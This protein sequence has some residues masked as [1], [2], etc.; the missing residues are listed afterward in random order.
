MKPRYDIDELKESWKELLDAEDLP[1]ITDRYKKNVT[2]V[3]LENTKE[4]LLE[5]SEQQ[6]N[7]AAPANQSNWGS[8]A[9]MQGYDPVLI[10]MIRQAIPKLMAFD[11]AGVQPLQGPVGLIFALT[12][13]YS[14]QDGDPMLFNEPDTTFSGKG[15]QTGTQPLP[16][17][18]DA[19]YTTG[20]GLTTLEGETPGDGVG[21]DFA[22]VSF[23]ITKTTV[24]VQTRGLKAEFTRELV[25]DLRAIH[26][27]D[28]ENELSNLI[29][30][31]LVAEINRQ[32][33]RTIYHNAYLG[34]QTG[35]TAAG[36]YDCD[37]DSDARWLV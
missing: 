22:E 23:S 12:P 33:V 32:L 9:N 26:G 4:D 16:Q 17:A 30:Q 31:E 37:L 20:T 8:G 25:Q 18:N 6:M 34:A 15:T 2:A 24:G 5:T 19:A 21:A 13:K 10:S 3:V 7:E 29:S 11:I 35:T 14:T 28:A 1:K 27:L 36:V